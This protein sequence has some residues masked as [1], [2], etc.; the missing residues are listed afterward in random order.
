[1]HTPY[2]PLPS[3]H[4]QPPSLPESNAG[5]ITRQGLHYNLRAVKSNSNSALLER[6]SPLVPA[7]EWAEMKS[8]GYAL[9]RETE[10]SASI[11]MHQQLLLSQKNRT[12]YA[13]VGNGQG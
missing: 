13:P 10:S 2:P 5:P 8:H 4:C 11:C 12:I 9:S 7:W 6:V 1:M 3:Q